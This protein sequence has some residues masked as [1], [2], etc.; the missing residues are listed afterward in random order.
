M[1]IRR[2]EFFHQVR[3]L[4]LEFGGNI[5][6][7]RRNEL[8]IEFSFRLVQIIED[9]IWNV[10]V[11][12]IEDSIGEGSGEFIHIFRSKWLHMILHIRLSVLDG[13]C[14]RMDFWEMN[15]WVS[16]MLLY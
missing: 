9:N 13:E 11:F 7:F 2:M 5:F 14:M 10:T 4:L 1:N 15:F 6:I 8:G 3:H 12:R 16:H